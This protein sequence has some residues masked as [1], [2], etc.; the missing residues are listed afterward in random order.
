MKFLADMGVSWRVIDWLRSQGHDAKHL[1][2]EGLQKLSDKDIFSKGASEGRIIL[3]FD[4]DFG[5]IAAF[6]TAA[7]VCTI[8]F[9]LHNTITPH[10]IDR[11]ASVLSD[12][13]QELQTGSIIIVEELRHRIRHLPIGRF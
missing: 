6:S 2:E 5:E 13:S 8:V 3:T 1:H 10:V 11:L 9:R 12:C 7:N 4:L